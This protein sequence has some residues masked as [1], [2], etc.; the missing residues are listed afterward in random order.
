MTADP[1]LA[2]VLAEVRLLRKELA[3]R[4]AGRLMRAGTAAAYLGLTRRSFY[5]LVAAGRLPEGVEVGVGKRW[6]VRQLDR[7]ADACR[8]RR[9]LRRLCRRRRLLRRRRQCR[10]RRRFLRRRRPSTG[11]GRD[12]RPHSGHRPPALPGRPDSITPRLINDFLLCQQDQA[13]R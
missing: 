4:P 6:D 3:A 12:P 11:E 2:D 13:R 7:Y 9:P 8:T 1:T 10:L 5:R